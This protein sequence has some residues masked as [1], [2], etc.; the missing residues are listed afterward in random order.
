[1]STSEYICETEQIAAYIEG[2]LEP[3]AS[4]AMTEHLSQCNRCNLELHSQQRFMCELESALADSTDLSVP[5]N[6][7]KVVAVRAESDMRGL[8]NSAEHRKALRLCFILALAVFALLGAGSI[9]AVLIKAQSTV[10]A[11]LGIIGLFGKATYDIASSLGVI[12]RVLSGGI[13]SDSR[14]ASFTALLLI[15]LA[16]GLLTLLISRYHRTRLSE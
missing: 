9:K 6:F 16:I 15:V 5:V 11:A 3:A 2:D 10:T 1:M 14:I 12:L 8:R 7:A 13:I 4:A